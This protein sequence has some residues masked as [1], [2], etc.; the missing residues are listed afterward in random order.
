ML[1]V[2]TICS[3]LRDF[4]LLVHI[5][6]VGPFHAAEPV[7]PWYKGFVSEIKLAVILGNEAR[8]LCSLGGKSMCKAE[9]FSN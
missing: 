2:L 5:L 4:H 7:T 9:N 8:T 6:Y 3:S 1:L